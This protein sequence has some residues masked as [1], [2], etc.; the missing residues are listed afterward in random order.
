MLHNRFL[1]ISQN[2]INDVR[3]VIKYYNQFEDPLGT[4]REKQK[5]LIE[6]AEAEAVQEASNIK[7]Q[8]PIKKWTPSFLKKQ[9]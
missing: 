5:K 9:F 1:A 2:Q 3:D 6:Q 8:P 4:F 7:N